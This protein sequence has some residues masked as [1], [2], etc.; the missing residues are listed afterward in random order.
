VLSVQCALCNFEALL[1]LAIAEGHEGDQ[2]L[3]DSLMA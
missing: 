2:Q 1:L 3:L